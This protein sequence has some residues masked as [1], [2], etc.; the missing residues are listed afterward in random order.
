MHCM[1]D[2]L[3]LELLE[4]IC[5]ELDTHDLASLLGTCRHTYHRTI[6]RLAQRYSEI[7]LDFSKG[8]LNQ[9]HAI[10]N[11]EI[12][13]QQVQR[14]VVMAPEPFLGRN[15]EWQRSAAGHI[16]NP[17][18]IPTIRQLRNDLVDKLINCRSFVIS[19]LGN[20]PAP[21]EDSLDVSDDQQFHPDDAASILLEIIA[22]AALPVKLFWYGRGMD[23]T[24]DIMNTQRLPKTLFLSPSFRAGWGALTN[25]HLEHKLTPYNYSFL[26]NMLL[27]T[28]NLRKLYLSL[29]PKELAIEFYAHVAKSDALSGV[30]E[31]VSLCCTCIRGSDLMQILERS[32]H[33]LR[34]LSLTE[35]GGPSGGLTQLHDQLSGFPSLAKVDCNMCA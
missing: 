22:D 3:P 16:L 19:P 26:L 15:L 29:A 8:S 2:K 23:Y 27:H 9:I 13:R 6:H 1:L 31:R 33:T 34:E 24:A 17:L 11:N 28:P 7:H 14:L 21:G 30:L 10:A 32:R 4:L 5:D 35:V 25:L 12:M 18:T 20:H